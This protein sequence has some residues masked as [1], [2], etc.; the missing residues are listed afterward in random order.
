[1]PR[2][3]NKTGDRYN[4]I[5]PTKLRLL[6]ETNGTKQEDLVS[7]LGVKARQSVTGYIDGSTVPSIDK[8]VS[9]ANYFD[10]TTDYLLTDTTVKNYDTE[11]RAVCDYTGLSESSIEQIK[12]LNDKRYWTIFASMH[13]FPKDFGNKV[14]QSIDD[15]FGSFAKPFFILMAKLESEIDF[16]DDYYTNEIT[17]PNGGNT[18]DWLEENGFSINQVKE[19]EVAVDKILHDLKATRT[20]LTDFFHDLISVL[21]YFRVT[22]LLQSTLYEL[23][24][25]HDRLES[26]GKNE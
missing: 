21:D 16:A 4:D 5:F 17:V 10:V 7:V 26:E 9:L 3:P 23:Y 14:N 1:M 15:F 19:F 22:D 20:D 25:Y 24:D 13:D 6:M 12:D 18:E 8:V 2:K 11:L